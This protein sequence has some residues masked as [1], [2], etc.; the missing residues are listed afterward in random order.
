MRSKR[1]PTLT[2]Q[3]C[4]VVAQRFAPL[5]GERVGRAGWVTTGAMRAKLALSEQLNRTS[6]MMLRELLPRA[7]NED[8]IGFVAHGRLP[9]VTTVSTGAQHAAED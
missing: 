2:T 8:R 4:G 3:I 6:V 9:N 5:D 7:E 1:I